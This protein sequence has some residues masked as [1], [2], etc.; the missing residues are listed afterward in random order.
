MVERGR[1]ASARAASCEAA[2]QVLPMVVVEDFGELAEKGLQ[3]C[4]WS[5]ADARPPGARPP[6]DYSVRAPDPPPWCRGRRAFPAAASSLPGCAS[7]LAADLKNLPGHGMAGAQHPPEIV[8]VE[9]EQ[10]GRL[11]HPSRGQPGNIQQQRDFARV[12]AR[13][14]RRPSGFPGDHKSRVTR[15][16]PSRIT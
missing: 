10:P 14:D 7:W 5:P 4:R 16:S 6:P 13:L 2:S 11:C 3:L 9:P 1:V 15:T 12:V 8:L